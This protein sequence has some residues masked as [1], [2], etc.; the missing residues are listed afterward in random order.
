[1]TDRLKRIIKGHI[2]GVMSY[3]CNSK[4]ALTQIIKMIEYRDKK[5]DRLQEDLEKALIKN[6]K[7]KQQ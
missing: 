2:Y 1:M 6:A 5:I 3:D 4:H 7:L